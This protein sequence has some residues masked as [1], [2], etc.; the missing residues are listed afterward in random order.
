MKLIGSNSYEI[1]KYKWQPVFY[2]TM[3][4]TLWLKE[5]RHC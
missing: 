1:F 3:E 2:I 4:R 5:C